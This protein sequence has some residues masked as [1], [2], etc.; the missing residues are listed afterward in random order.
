VPM[1]SEEDLRMM[2]AEDVGVKFDDP[3]KEAKEFPYLIRISTP[4]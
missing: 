3:D 1:P 4:K 2:E